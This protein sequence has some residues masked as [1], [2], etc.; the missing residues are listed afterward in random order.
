MDAASGRAERLRHRRKYA[1]GDMAAPTPTPA[2]SVNTV[3]IM[4][5]SY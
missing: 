5:I 1:E 2:A 4:I 3:R